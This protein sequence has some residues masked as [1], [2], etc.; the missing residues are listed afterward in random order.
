MNC[1]NAG[2]GIAAALFRPSSGTSPP[3]YVLLASNGTSSNYD[4]WNSFSLQTWIWVSS[5]SGTNADRAIAVK[6]PRV[7]N[8][9]LV[10]FSNGLTVQQEF[11]LMLTARGGLRFR[12]GCSSD[13]GFDAETLNLIANTT[14]TNVAVVM[15]NSGATANVVLYVNGNRQQLVDGTYQANWRS[16]S[17]SGT[18]GPYRTVLQGQSVATPRVVG[19]LIQLGMYNVQYSSRP[20]VFSGMMDE[21]SVWNRTLMDYEVAI[22]QNNELRGDETGLL[23]I[24]NFNAQ[25]N[26][27]VLSPYPNDGPFRYAPS[28]LPTVPGYLSNGASLTASG[29]AL[30]YPVINVQGNTTIPIYGDDTSNN[31]GDLYYI[32]TSIP[33]HGSL[34][35]TAG[36]VVVGTRIN[37]V[38]GSFPTI[39]FTPDTGYAGQDDFTYTAYANVGGTY[40]SCTPAAGLGAVVYL[41]VSY[42]PSTTPSLSASISPSTVATASPS[43]STIAT[44][45]AT[46]SPSPST[47]ATAT[48]SPSTLTLTLTLTPTPTPTASPSMCPNQDPCRSTPC[49]CDGIPNSNTSYD[50]CG[51]CGG[52]NE[53][54]DCNGVPNGPNPPTACGCCPI[55]ITTGNGTMTTTVNGTQM[56]S[57]PNGQMMTNGTYCVDCNGCPFGNATFDICGVCGGNGTSCLGCNGVINGP[58]ADLCGVCNSDTTM[59]D[60]SCGVPICNNDPNIVPDACGVCGGDNSSC[61]CKFYQNYQVSKLDCSLIEFSINNTLCI[62]DQLIGELEQSYQ[63]IVNATN[64]G[65]IGVYVSLFQGEI[66]S[67]T[68]FITLGSSVGLNGNGTQSNDDVGCLNRFCFEL[69]QTI[70]DV[71][72]FV[73]LPANFTLGNGTTTV[74]NGGNGNGTSTVPTGNGNGNGTISGGGSAVTRK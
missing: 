15:D 60:Q 10:S 2:Y 29:V 72:Q 26:N 27:I 35:N 73:T 61:Q 20:Y 38:A 30:N 46:A 59:T 56:Y 8:A 24:H 34:S 1:G 19:G 18:T 25:Q 16:A 64:D 54:L 44:A 7:Q 43:P 47:I 40:I 71:E 37:S 31:N 6:T 63:R 12:M 17:C 49:G 36:P 45:T 42:L 62:I 48:A 69:S 9:D 58:V 32:I 39:T 53:C 14:W 65:T 21:F 4:N 70:E 11:S 33:T 68:N 57:C 5:S 51:V 23:T 74:P 67:L 22:N 13:Y 41:N 55:M 52:D 28:S 3:P 50:R 66:V